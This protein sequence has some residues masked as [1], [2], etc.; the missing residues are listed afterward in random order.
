MKWNNKKVEQNS[1]NK[2]PWKSYKKHEQEGKKWNSHPLRRITNKNQTFYIFCSFPSSSSVLVFPRKG[3]AKTIFLNIFLAFEK[4]KNRIK[5]ENI[6]SDIIWVSERR[7]GHLCSS[8]LSVC[9]MHD[10]GFFLRL[11]LVARCYVFWFEWRRE[12]RWWKGLLAFFSYA[13][14]WTEGCGLC[15]KRIKIKYLWGLRMREIE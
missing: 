9:Y 14:S 13:L 1:Q 3:K 4:E 12:G 11:L 15:E 6:F 7:G 2:K 5:L 10:G 8:F